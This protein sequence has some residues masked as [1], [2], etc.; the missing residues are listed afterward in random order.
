MDAKGQ[1]I[2]YIVD[3]DANVRRTER[4]LLESE[5]IRVFDFPSAEDFL[6]QTNLETGAAQCLLLDLRLPGM[7]G[8]GLQQELLRRGQ[9]MP[10]IVQTGFPDLSPAINV[11]KAGA[12][13][14]LEKPVGA[15]EL[16]DCVSKAHAQ[17]RARRTREAECRQFQQALATL[18]ARERQVMDG[19]VAGNRVKELALT[20]EIG[21]QTVLKHRASMLKKL[22]ARN[23]VHLVMLLAA[24]DLAPSSTSRTA[25]VNTSLEKGLLNNRVSS[26][27]SGDSPSS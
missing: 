20:L 2:V 14:V 22:G 6:A 1:A 7:D 19:L 13:E 16:L 17:D 9:K 26:E 3:D 12:I 4:L 18:S 15:D 23:E 27:S 21:T 8:P 25:L 5:A 11:M 24:Y 10:I